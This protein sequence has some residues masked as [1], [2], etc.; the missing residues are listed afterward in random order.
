MT[1]DEILHQLQHVP[2]RADFAPYE[3]ALLAAVEQR[4]A[5]TP[6]LI[7]ALDRVSADPAHFLKHGEECLHLFAIYLLAQFRERRALDAFIRFFSL[8]GEVALDLTGDMVME[9]GA[10]V[11]ASVCGGDPAPLLRLAHDES[12]NEYVRG[13]AIAGLLVQSVWGERSREAVITDL[14]GF[15]SS[16]PEPGD[17]FVWAELVG[18]VSDFNALELLPEVRRA[19]VEELVDESIIGLDD[20]DPA[21]MHEQREYPPPSPEERFRW[22]CER[23]APIDAVA[24]CSSWLCFDDE[25]EEDLEPWEEDILIDS[26][27]CRASDPAEDY[28]YRAPLPPQPY[29]APPKIGRNETC[30][31]GSGKKYKKCCGK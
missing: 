15:F 5:I 1:I 29:I 27:V 22:F 12:V 31:C 25:E 4:D 6:A 20:I 13:Q 17:G 7:A 23:N 11:I 10:A 21:E 30:P 8:P 16:L 3:A 14:R 18:A 28:D 19:F 26:E 2:D 9:N 24:E